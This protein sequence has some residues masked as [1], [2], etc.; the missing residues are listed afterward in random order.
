MNGI[1][2][3]SACVIMKAMPF[4]LGHEFLIDSA[5]E[6]AT[7]VTVLI[8]SLSSDPIKGY[9]RYNWIRTTY[10]G[11]VD[12]IHI[13]NDTLIQYPRSESDTE[14]WMQ[15]TQLVK[16]HVPT[17]DLIVSSEAY[18]KTFSEYLKSDYLCVDLDRVNVPI[19]AT[20]IRQD[21]ESNFNFLTEASKPYFAK[22]IVFVGAESTGKTTLSLQIA[23]HYQL[24]HVPEAGRTYW[25]AKITDNDAFSIDDIDN[26]MLWQLR[27]EDQII[28]KSPKPYVIMDTDLLETVT[29]S[30]LYF[31]H[32]RDWVYDL[33]LRHADNSIYLLLDNCI[34]WQNDGT[35][36]NE[37]N[38]KRHYNLILNELTKR[39]A[40]FYLIN[41][42][43]NR[44]EQ[45][46]EVLDGLFTKKI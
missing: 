45:C 35:R 23:N 6:A 34:D 5:L 42:R 39:K 33:S 40:E 2:Y 37:Q 28:G 26:I 15:W 14:F 18:G 8:C 44:F 24:S 10:H 38:R 9:L 16:Q 25:E 31:N 1:K 17:I 36:F 29:W 27:S 12:V 22:R 41:G 3:T 7:K 19:S 4:H 11:T 46:L 43:E 21:L 20:R 13:F 30:Y 32:V